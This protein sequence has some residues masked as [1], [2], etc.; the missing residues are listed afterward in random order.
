MPSRFSASGAQRVVQPRTVWLPE[1]FDEIRPWLPEARRRTRSSRL[2]YFN[3]SKA[4]ECRLLAGPTM[5]CTS[6][7]CTCCSWISRSCWYERKEPLSSKDSG[8][9][10]RD[11]FNGID[12]PRIAVRHQD[13]QIFEENC[14]AKDDRTNE[15]VTTWIPA[16]KQKAKNCKCAD[17]FEYNDEGGLRCR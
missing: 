1:C 15:P 9:A 8:P 4:C 16:R 17:T 6:S 7:S 11:L 5:G 3:V 12:H 2:N 14:A 10:A 13:L